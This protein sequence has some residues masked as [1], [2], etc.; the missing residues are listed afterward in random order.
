MSKKESSKE[1]R[2]RAD[3]LTRNVEEK[4]VLIRELQ[5]S[6]TR[7]AEEC[8][9][10]KQREARIKRDLQEKVQLIEIQCKTF[11]EDFE[12]ERRER[13]ELRE[14]LDEAKARILAL[15]RSLHEEK[16][17]Q[18]CNRQP[19]AITAE[20]LHELEEENKRMKVQINNYSIENDKLSKALQLVKNRCETLDEQIKEQSIIPSEVRRRSSTCLP[21]TDYYRHQ[22]SHDYTDNDMPLPD[23]R[24]FLT[25]Q[26]SESYPPAM[27]IDQMQSALG[28]QQHQEMQQQQQLNNYN[29]I[30]RYQDEQQCI[31]KSS[32]FPSG[33]SCSY[34][35]FEV[36]LDIIG[37]DD[38]LGNDDGCNIP[39]GGRRHRAFTQQLIESYPPVMSA[40]EMQRWAQQ[41]Q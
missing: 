27:S 25:L 37:N 38:G 26:M 19:A 1:V 2:R 34:D 29:R 6:I 3:T 12:T 4:D 28:L 40:D 30:E 13:E 15:E 20:E 36:S 35:Q 10:V 23:E 16:Q 11:Q 14:K 31:D 41:R 17:R 5:A 39:D 7:Q 32:T 9:E 8:E 18:P 24:P 33:T 21:N 22:V